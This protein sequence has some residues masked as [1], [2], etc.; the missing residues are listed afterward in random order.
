[1]TTS[2]SLDMLITA[3]MD[4]KMGATWFRQDAFRVMTAS[5]VDAPKTPKV[6]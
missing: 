2:V 4:Y 6:K 3:R 5:G 1:M